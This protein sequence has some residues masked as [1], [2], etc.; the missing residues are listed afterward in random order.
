MESSLTL[1]RFN[2]DCRNI[3]GIDVRSE[4]VIKR[5]QR[6]GNRHPM[7]GCRKRYM[8]DTSRHWAEFS[9]VRLDL[10][11]QRARQEGASVEAAGKGNDI[12]TSSICTRDLHR[13]LDR[14]CAR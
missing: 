14:F 12:S 4:Q 2:Y 10:A 9:L 7:L 5:L 8:P 13:V 1:H 11:R 3:R 6:I